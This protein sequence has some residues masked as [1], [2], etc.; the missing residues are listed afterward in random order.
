MIEMSIGQFV[1]AQVNVP[2]GHYFSEIRRSRSR[3]CFAVMLQNVYAY[4]SL[5][6]GPNLSRQCT[7]ADN[8]TRRKS[9]S[10]Q[11]RNDWGP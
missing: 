10:K 2:S 6:T 5:H 4:S 9:I 3:R 8:L 7:V 1:A 11:F